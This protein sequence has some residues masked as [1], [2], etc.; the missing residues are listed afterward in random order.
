MKKFLY[1]LLGLALLFI[2]GCSSTTMIQTEPPGAKVYADNMLL[3][4]SPVQIKDYKFATS[5]TYIKLEKEGYE[6]LN[7]VICKDEKI[8]VGAAIA[9]LFLYYPWVWV[10]EYQP[11]HN[12]VMQPIGNDEEY[13]YNDDNVD[14]TNNN[15][16][17]NSKSHKLREIKKLYDDGILSKE[18]YETE[19]NKI[20]NQE[21]W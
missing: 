5:S 1:S 19:K 21:D 4:E 9:G 10:L 7:T 11:V 12:Y 20:L 3:G 15:Q 8:H 6:T 18:E 13:Y 16:T 14:N 17:N 2:T